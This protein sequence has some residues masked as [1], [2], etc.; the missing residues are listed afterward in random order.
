[1]SLI[2]VVDPSQIAFKRPWTLAAQ[3]TLNG[4]EL[5][6]LAQETEITCEAFH[7]HIDVALSGE[8]VE[9][10]RIAD[11]TMNTHDTYSLLA[12][13]LRQ[14]HYELYGLEFI[15]WTGLDSKLDDEIFDQLDRKV[16]DLSVLRVDQMSGLN[17]IVK[18]DFAE[19]V[20][21]IIQSSYQVR[22]LSLVQNRLNFAET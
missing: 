1:M 12:C 3:V 21:R 5:I 8:K 13:V 6:E 16:H 10:I 18:H 17:Q 20:M 9:R 4:V 15:N 2:G 19:K 22:E 11:L 7:A 14:A